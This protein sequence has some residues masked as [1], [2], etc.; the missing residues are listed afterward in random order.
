MWRLKK[1]SQRRIFQYRK[2]TW[3][4]RALPN[5][6]ILGAQKA[7]TTSLYEYLSQHPK[8]V[9][10]YTKEVHY[11]DG[12]IESNE[13]CFYKGEAWYRAHFPL[14][15]KLAQSKRTFEASPLYLFHPYAPMRISELIPK[16]KLVVLLRNPVE[17]A[18]SQYFHEKRTG[19]ETLPIMDAFQAEGRRLRRAIDMRDYND[20]SYIHHTYL[21]RGLYHQ[22][23]IRYLEC[24][25]RHQILILN[26]EEFFT[27]PS[28]TL[29]S[30]FAF[31]EVDD[32]VT[33]EDLKPRNVG[34]SKE[35]VGSS[36]YKY[37]EDYFRPH[38]QK[39]YDLIGQDYGW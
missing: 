34:I 10:S 8:L 3:R 39:L 24:F 19:D 21:S 16:A 15:W 18:I 4:V 2:A 1:L 11:F 27:H 5:F 13:N 38:N 9:P 12:G 31:A 23:L 26:S 30:V 32:K 36:V 6:I 29:K 20:Y 22:Q 33:L 35:K 14:R 25:D 28:K 7:G 37:L 17:R